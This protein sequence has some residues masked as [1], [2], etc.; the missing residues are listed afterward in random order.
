MRVAH[1]RP[2]GRNEALENNAVDYQ[3]TFGQFRELVS[4]LQAEL[5]AAKAEQA[6]YGGAEGSG[7]KQMADQAMLNLNLKLQS[8]ALKS[9]AKTIDLELGRLQAAQASSHLEMVRTYLP[10]AR[11]LRRTPTRSTACSSSDA[12][13]SRAT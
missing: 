13:R 6:E 3:N 7:R 2:C 12:W 5:E 4:N 10:A 1:P 11:T 9:Q 8:S